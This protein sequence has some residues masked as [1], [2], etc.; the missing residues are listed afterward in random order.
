M[1][2][3]YN[4]GNVGVLVFF[5]ISGFLISHSYFRSQGVLQ[6]LGRRVRRIYPGYLAATMIGAFIIVPLFSS[7][8]LTDLSASEILKAIGLNLLLQNYAPPSDVFGG[9]VINGSLWSIPY[10]FWCYLGLAILGVTYLLSKRAL[11]LA[12]VGATMA[13]P[14]LAR[15]DRSKTGRRHYRPHH[16]L[17]LSLVHSVAVFYVRR[18][19]VSLS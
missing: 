4:A 17:A 16:R 8:T 14:D 6:F 10:E 11:C 3:T 2:A 7:R 9:G 5:I 19:R 12:I 15:F 1:N 18:N 13:V